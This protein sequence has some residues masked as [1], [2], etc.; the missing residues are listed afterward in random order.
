MYVDDEA[1]NLASFRATFRKDYPIYIARSGNEALET[2]RSHHIH[3]VISDQR[4]P[5]MTGVQFLEQV[6]RE[7]PDTIRMVL[8][9]YSDM[10]AIVAAINTGGVFRF[11]SKPWEESELRMTLENAR[12]LH[13]LQ[14][15]N[16]TLVSQLRQKVEEQERTLRLFMRYIPEPVVK[17][18]LSQQ[19]EDSFLEGE[20]RNVAVLFCDIRGFTAFSEALAPRQV[21]AFLNRYY[22]LMAACIKR[23]HGSVNQ[24]VGDEVFATFGAPLSYPNNEENAVFCA[25][26]MMENLPVLR[27]EFKD[28]LPPDFQIGMGIGI[29][30]GEVVAGNLG[31]ED[32]IDYSITGDTVNTGKRI[33]TLAKDD[34]HAIL[35]SESI[36]DKTQDLIDVTPWEPI[37]VKGK[38]DKVCVFSVNGRK[39]R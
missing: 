10:E 26:E 30:S 23:H 12:Q 32:R 25:L 19:H 8:T 14:T 2:L 13:D 20:L 3:L 15:Q 33:E 38:K 24:Y 4:M 39:Y 31:S 34:Q 27:E 5:G 16:K 28:V 11:V 6:N 18:A 7:Y 21:V 1:H 36:Y 37:Y 29:N 9:G 22:S 17:Q 35:I